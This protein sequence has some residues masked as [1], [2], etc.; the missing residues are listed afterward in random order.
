MNVTGAKSSSKGLSAMGLAVRDLGVMCNDGST[1]DICFRAVVKYL[2]EDK[3]FR[4]SAARLSEALKDYRRCHS[5]IGAKI[6]EA[7]SARPDVSECVA[8]VPGQVNLFTANRRE[9]RRVLKF[10]HKAYHMKYAENGGTREGVIAELMASCPKLRYD[11]LRQESADGELQPSEADSEKSITEILKRF[12]GARTADADQLCREILLCFSTERLATGSS[13]EQRAGVNRVC[14]CYDVPQNTG[15]TIVGK[16]LLVLGDISGTVTAVGH[17]S[18]P[19]LPRLFVHG[20]SRG[21]KVEGFGSVI[22]TGSNRGCIRVHGQIGGSEATLGGSNLGKIYMVQQ[23]GAVRLSNGA[24]GSEG[25]TGTAQSEVA[26]RTW[27]SGK[28]SLNVMGNN[29]GTIRIAGNSTHKSDALI[30]GANTGRIFCDNTNLKVRGYSTMWIR[31]QKSGP[32]PSMTRSSSIFSSISS[33]ISRLFSRRTSTNVVQEP[34]DSPSGNNRSYVHAVHC[35]IEIAANQLSGLLVCGEGNTIELT[36]AGRTSDTTYDVKN[37]KMFLR[38]SKIRQGTGGA[39]VRYVR[40]SN[41]RLERG[42]ISLPNSEISLSVVDLRE[43]S[44]LTAHKMRSCNVVLKDFSNVCIDGEMHLCR[45]LMLRDRDTRGTKCVHRG[46]LDTFRLDV[47]VIRG[48]LIYVEQGDVFAHCVQNTHLVVGECG[49][50]SVAYFKKGYVCVGERLHL[51]RDTGPPDK[52]VRFASTVSCVY[53]IP[54]VG[55]A[56]KFVYDTPLKRDRS[57]KGD[58]CVARFGYVEDT[59]V[60]AGYVPHQ[61]VLL[62]AREMKRCAFCIRQKGRIGAGILEECSGEVIG[63]GVELEACMVLNSTVKLTGDSRLV[64][65]E[66]IRG[67]LIGVGTASTVL[68][69]C[70]GNVTNK[71]VVGASRYGLVLGEFAARCT[72]SKWVPKSSRGLVIGS[73]TVRTADEESLVGR[74]DVVRFYGMQQRLT[75]YRPAQSD[76]LI[77]HAQIE[78]KRNYFRDSA[79]NVMDM[80]RCAHEDMLC[81]ASKQC[82]E[83]SESDCGVLRAPL[84]HEGK[85][86]DMGGVAVCQEKRESATSASSRDRDTNF[87]GKSKVCGEPQ[88]GTSRITK[89]PCD[90]RLS[91]MAGGEY[92]TIED[93]RRLRECYEAELAQKA[94]QSRTVNASGTNTSDCRSPLSR[95]PEADARTPSRA[96]LTLPIGER[97]GMGDGNVNPSRRKRLVASRA[98]GTEKAPPVR[99][100]SVLP[101]VSTDSTGGVRNIGSVEIHNGGNEGNNIGLLDI[102]SVSEVDNSKLIA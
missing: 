36:G 86:A 60:F 63:D 44:S 51:Q 22:V 71:A 65:P 3:N 70:D 67:S 64:V 8:R 85:F 87:A 74:S 89:G 75:S 39:E 6:N 90:V 95:C 35:D 31:Q 24:C 84:D 29:S 50:V 102:T 13:R 76:F 15:L 20:V 42:E 92:E 2:A 81:A 46:R 38:S 78:S 100:A 91:H 33:W 10:F 18:L 97:A 47:P 99:G 5:V 21:G 34:A 43:T 73:D 32:K 17:S 62:S 77:E 101:V 53:E 40:E 28:F 79:A 54:V 49:N 16:E 69:L 11:G 80:A 12:S 27:T 48:G 25:S 55:G 82:R 93:V 59:E 37:C 4:R 45:V 14:I 83:L 61:D 7:I 72:A 88:R 52:R 26:G 23:E 30:Q 57:E 58:A 94:R 98:A 9:V 66:S 19:N 56:R 41:I 68:W 96:H 1:E